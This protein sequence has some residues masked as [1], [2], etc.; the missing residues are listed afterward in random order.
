[1]SLT[2]KI[3]KRFLGKITLAS[4]AMIGLPVFAQAGENL[5]I[6]VPVAQSGPVGVADHQDFLNGLNLAIGEINAT[7]G[8]NGQMIEAKVVDTDLLT[9]EGTVASFQLLTSANVD[10]IAGPFVLIPD[11][12][13]DA[14]SATGVPYLHTMTADYA[15]QQVRN[16]PEK[17]RNV[18]QIDVAETH[19]GKGYIDFL[20]QMRDSGAQ[21]FRNNRIH[22]V[23][24]QIAFTQTIAAATKAAIEAT[25]GDWE[26]AGVTDIQF[27]VSDWSPVIAALKETDAS[28]ILINY[29]VAAELA[30]FAQTYANDPVPDSLVYL[31]YGPSQP[32]FLELSAGAAENMVWST[33]YGVYADEQGQSF[34]DGYTATYP[35]SAMGLSLTGGGYDAVYMLKA[36]WEQ[37]GDTSDYDEVGDALRQLTYRGVN[38]FYQFDNANQAPISF[39][40]ETDNLEEAQAHLFFQVQDNEHKIVWPF[41]L[42]ESELR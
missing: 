6:G 31:Q 29:W 34:R 38:G 12:A 17:Y 9:P 18:F 11:A 16:N 26:L 3:S 33:V 13:L 40:N 4:L 21:E 32:E 14:T 42:A 19:Y 22:I 15:L 10:A 30:T 25:G 41:E 28:A 20:T 35:G 37:V 5:V 7:G 23:T 24:G 36:A 8:V 2:H 39:P 1:M 27:P